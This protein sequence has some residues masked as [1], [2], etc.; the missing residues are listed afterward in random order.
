MGIASVGSSVVKPR[1]NDLCWCG[2]GKKYKKCHWQLELS[3]P[4]KAY[5]IEGA[6][7]KKLNV[8]V[9]MAGSGAF[10]LECSKKIIA[11]H[12]ISRRAALERVAR[13]GHV[14]AIS[15]SFS[16]L[17]KSGG[18]L[19]PVLRGIH[20]T[21]TFHGFCSSHD[22]SIF[23]LIDALHPVVDAAFCNRLA[24]RAVCKELYLKKYMQRDQEQVRLLQMGRTPEYQ[25]FI[26]GCFEGINA[27]MHAAARD[28]DAYRI[29]LAEAISSRDMEWSHYVVQ[30]RGQLPLAASSIFQP[31]KNLFGELLQDLA[32]ME[33]PSQPVIF[34]A[35]PVVDGG[36]IVLS[37]R[38]DDRLARSYVES[39]TALSDASLVPYLVGLAFEYCENIAIL[40]EWWDGLSHASRLECLRAINRGTSTFGE[41]SSVLNPLS[42]RV[43]AVPLLLG[44]KMIA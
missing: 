7:R 31:E 10:G 2:S 43:D 6:L 20:K 3:A 32:D 33:M 39:I 24:Y 16:Q 27:G 35:I 13:E 1:R 26:Y 34:S 12:T 29:S 9:C 23:K 25:Q 17:D 38:S 37:F 4:A 15:P 19:V 14:Y 44:K 28:L 22:D 30:V 5:D 21:S 11:S 42:F 8:S 18:V 41:N 40:P 36:Y